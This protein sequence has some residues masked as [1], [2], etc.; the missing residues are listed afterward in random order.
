MATETVVRLAADGF[1][2]VAYERFADHPEQVVGE[3]LAFVGEPSASPAFVGPSTVKL[4]A[5]HSTGG[6]PGRF[7]R[8]EQVIALDDRWRTAL[9]AG[10]KRQVERITTPVRQLLGYR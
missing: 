3:L 4:E 2:R 1:R 9:D 7:A 6:N 5:T 8:H 10:A